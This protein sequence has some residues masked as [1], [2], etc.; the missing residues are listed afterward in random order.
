MVQHDEFLAQNA[1]TV[2]RFYSRASDTINSLCLPSAGH[3]ASSLSG[4]ISS[5]DITSQQNKKL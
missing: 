5:P 4:R 3:D 1:E 2:D